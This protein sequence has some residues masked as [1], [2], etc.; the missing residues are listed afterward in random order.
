MIAS[1]T[2]GAISKHE[3]A[4]G[5]KFSAALT[6]S[7]QIF[8]DLISLKEKQMECIWRITYL[9]E[10]VLVVFPTGFDKRHDSESDKIVSPHWVIVVSLEY[11]W[12]QQVENLKNTH[13]RIES[14]LRLKW[15]FNNPASN[16]FGTLLQSPRPEDVIDPTKLYQ[17]WTMRRV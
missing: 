7:L 6:S 15:F 11:T 9:E 10:D 12:R 8:A 2:S 17:H 5:D 14:V 3:T 4:F 13:W 1:L 16:L